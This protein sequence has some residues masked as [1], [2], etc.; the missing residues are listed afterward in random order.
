MFNFHLERLESV[1]TCLSYFGR[2]F[3]AK[4]VEIKDMLTTCLSPPQVRNDGEGTR[5][6]T[7]FGIRVII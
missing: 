1:L 7:F 5:S 6:S 3:Y 4:L 2:T